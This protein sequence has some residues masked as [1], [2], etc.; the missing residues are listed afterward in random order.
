MIPVMYL[1]VGVNW[2]DAHLYERDLPFVGMMSLFVGLAFLFF[3]KLFD[4]FSAR[5]KNIRK[6]VKRFEELGGKFF[7][8]FTPDKK[9][10]D[11]SLK[12]WCKSVLVEKATT[13]LIC[14]QDGESYR[15]AFNRALDLLVSVRILSED[16]IKVWYKEIFDEAVPLVKE[17]INPSSL[18]SGKPA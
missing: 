2:S 1:M 7:K 5:N 13:I 9:P 11:Q 4:F 18:S 3:C 14:G 12:V 10:L 17:M 15:P 8:T 6:Y 16:E